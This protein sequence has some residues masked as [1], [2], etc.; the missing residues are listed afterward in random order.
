MGRSLGS[1]SHLF[2]GYLGSANNFRVA[3]L[4]R[5]ALNDTLKPSTTLSHEVEVR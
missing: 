5:C 1:L 4:V 3:N 2:D